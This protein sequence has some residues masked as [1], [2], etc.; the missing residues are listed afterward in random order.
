MNRTV[1]TCSNCSGRV[2]VPDLWLGVGPPIATCEQ[3]GATKKQPHGPVIDMD[4]PPVN[5][6][7]V[8]R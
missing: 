7:T 8:K 2:A 3:C 6:S 4:D 5:R 1:G